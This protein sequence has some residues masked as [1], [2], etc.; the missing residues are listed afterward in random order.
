[1]PHHTPSAANSNTHDDCSTTPQHPQ[2]QARL[3][4]ARQTP[5]S[6]EPQGSNRWIEAKANR[7]WWVEKLAK[8]V[9]RDQETNLTLQAA[10]WK[11]I[12]VW[13]HEDLAVAADRIERE[14]RLRKHTHSRP[15]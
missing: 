9:K 12:R 4:R 8:N 13:E 6:P 14:V 5:H 7:E 2:R 11:V 15:A 1:V 10:G 3:R